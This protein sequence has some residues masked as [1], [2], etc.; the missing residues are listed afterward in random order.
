LR[1]DRWQVPVPQRIKQFERPNKIAFVDRPRLTEEVM[2][3]EVN[4]AHNK[5]RHT[6]LNLSH[7]FTRQRLDDWRSHD[8]VTLCS[9]RDQWQPIGQ[10]GLNCDWLKFNED[11]CVR[12]W[13]VS[14]TV[15]NGSV[16]LAQKFKLP[17]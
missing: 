13:R 1:H 14:K 7:R 2:Q 16:W 11:G 4:L 8:H 5:W 10:N 17:T 9:A 12:L 6:C 3:T 15:W